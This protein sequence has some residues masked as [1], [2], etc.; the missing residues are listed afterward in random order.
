LGKIGLL[1]GAAEMFTVIDLYKR[2]TAKVDGL[3]TG[4]FT[5][6]NKPRPACGSPDNL[7][8]YTYAA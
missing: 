4:C 7:M 6:R 1:T 2:M 3:M 5:D 8:H